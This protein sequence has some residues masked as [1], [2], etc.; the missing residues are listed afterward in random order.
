MDVS[1]F[2]S[3]G[4]R[5]GMFTRAS[6]ALAIK[7]FDVRGPIAMTQAP[8]SLRDI[9]QTILAANGLDQKKSVNTASETRDVFS[10]SPTADREREF[11]FYVWEHKYWAEEV[12]PPITTLK[13]NGRRKDPQS[14]SIPGSA[15]RPIE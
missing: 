14:W 5:I 10:V 3:R 7:P 4:I 13:I 9:P 8:V 11:L 6:A 1:K 15:V 2:K 12:L